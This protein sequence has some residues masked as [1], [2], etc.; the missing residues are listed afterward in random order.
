MMKNYCHGKKSF[1]NALIHLCRI[2]FAC[3]FVLSCCHWDSFPIYG[4]WTGS[5]FDVNVHGVFD[6]DD[7]DSGLVR[8]LSMI[9]LLSNSYSY[10][11]AFFQFFFFR[12]SFE[13]TWNERMCSCAHLKVGAQR[14][15]LSSTR[16]EPETIINRIMKIIIKII[17][18]R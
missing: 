8:S 14:D 9:P 10:S 16:Q 2:L 1:V 11:F 18:W 12:L 13:A 3:Y 6:D 7:D 15:E 17:N 4:S 5:R